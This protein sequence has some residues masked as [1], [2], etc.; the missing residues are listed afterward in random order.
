MRELV[1]L[2][3]TAAVACSINWQFWLTTI[4]NPF[5]SN[6]KPD[7]LIFFFVIIHVHDIIRSSNNIT[8]FH[9][10]TFLKVTIAN[11]TI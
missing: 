3:V 5:W 8:D 4:L 7:W 1:F 6:H 11:T 10:I 2:Y 9:M